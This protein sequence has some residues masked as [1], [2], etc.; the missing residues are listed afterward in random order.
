MAKKAGAVAPEVKWNVGGK[1]TGG[2]DQIKNKGDGMQPGDIIIMEAGGLWHHAIVA[3]IDEPWVSTIDGNSFDQKTGQNQS[4]VEH[5][6][7]RNR[8]EISAW[9]KTVADE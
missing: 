1:I 3:S 2:L 8:S 5:S 4:V 9:Y 7:N 6:K